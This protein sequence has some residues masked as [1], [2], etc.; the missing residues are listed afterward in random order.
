[1]NACRISIHPLTLYSSHLSSTPSSTHPQNKKETPNTSIIQP[2]PPSY[3]ENP[4]TGTRMLLPHRWHHLTYILIPHQHPSPAVLSDL[5]SPPS[6]MKMI[7]GRESVDAESWLWD[8]YICVNTF[9]IIY[10][11]TLI[12]ISLPLR[13]SP[14]FNLFPFPFALSSPLLS[15]PSPS[16]NPSHLYHPPSTTWHL[17]IPS[18]PFLPFK[19]PRQSIESE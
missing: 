19:N 8:R 3:T 13:I 2:H 1:M 12:S 14:P 17:T 7:W 11:T 5:N 6:T 9:Y 4:H 15:S 18:F 16:L 10:S